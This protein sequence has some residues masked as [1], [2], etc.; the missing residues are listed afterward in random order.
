MTERCALVVEDSPTMRQ[1][2]ALGLRRVANLSLVEAENGVEALGLMDEQQF[3]LIL[4][5]L[6]MPVMAGFAFL[7]ELRT[8]DNVPPVI[9]ITTESGQ[10]DIDRAIALGAAAYI[11]KPVRAPDLADTIRQVLGE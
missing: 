4:L 8:R 10:E 2:I 6:N 7:E 9:V 1:L 5:D 11:M 3:D